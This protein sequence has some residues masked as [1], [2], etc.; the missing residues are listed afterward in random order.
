MR[1]GVVLLCAML[2]AVNVRAGDDDKPPPY[3]IY[4]DPE[5]GRYTTEDPLAKLE[6]MP[7][8]KAPAPVVDDADRSAAILSVVVITGLAAAAIMLYRR[9]PTT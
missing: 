3:R 8:V 1:A 9:Q 4:I 6:D 7:V 5:T 2:A